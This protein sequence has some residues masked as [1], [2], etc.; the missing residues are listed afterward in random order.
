VRKSRPAGD[1]IEEKNEE[2][3][4]VGGMMRGVATRETEAARLFFPRFKYIVHY[5]NIITLTSLSCLRCVICRSVVLIG[6]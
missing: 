5:L 6:H 2:A 4:K 1:A 3:D